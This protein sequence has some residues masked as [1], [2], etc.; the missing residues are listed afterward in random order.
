[1][2][3]LEITQPDSSITLE[4]ALGVPVSAINLEDLQNVNIVDPQEGDV[5]VY[6]S[7][8]WTNQQP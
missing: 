6:Q 3:T 5:L 4:V 7:G 8:V 1:M 2:N